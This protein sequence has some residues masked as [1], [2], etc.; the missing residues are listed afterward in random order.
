MRDPSKR[1]TTRIKPKSLSP[2]GKS[3][4]LEEEIAK[5]KLQAIASTVRLQEMN[6]H[7]ELLRAFAQTIETV[8]LHVC[9]NPF[10]SNI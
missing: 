1:T 10:A 3:K 2:I 4:L 5:A 6:S 8:G 9:K 7:R